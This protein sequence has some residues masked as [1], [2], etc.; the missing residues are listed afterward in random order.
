MSIVASSEFAFTQQDFDLIA[1]TLYDETGI[2]LDNSKATLVYSRLTKRL[3]VLGIESFRDYCSLVSDSGNEEHARMCAALTTNVTRFFRENHHFE[4]LKTKVL[5]GLI[6]AARAGKKIRIWS[7]GCSSGEEPYSIALTILSILPAAREYDIRILATDINPHVIATGKAGLY[8][9]SEMSDVDS[10]LRSKWMERVIV[11]GVKH[12][13]LD[14]DVRSLISFRPLNLMG[15]WP[16]SGPFQVMFCRNV[17]IYFDAPT[18]A[19]I[20]SRMLPLLD[21]NGVLY[22]GHSER[23]TGTALAQTQADGTTTYRKIIKAAA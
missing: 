18:Q 2:T 6:S 12:Y 15:A 5:P 1:R 7:A 10:A 13:Q 19:R 8:P 22:I 14:N 20:W 21:T 23:V 4:H 3:R 16:M 17:V 11:K 9:E